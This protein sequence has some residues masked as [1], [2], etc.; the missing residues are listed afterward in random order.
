[1]ARP[2]KRIIPNQ[3]LSLFAQSSQESLLQPIA[4][5]SP[6]PPPSAKPPTPPRIEP[7]TSIQN[8]NTAKFTIALTG[9]API[10]IEKPDW[11]IIAQTR[12]EV[13]E[14]DHLKKFRLVV[15]QHADG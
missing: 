7:P 1:M 6:P 9:R 10:T 13:R 8:P 12:Y 11:P 14:D 3:M 4:A 15:R 2:A 5:V